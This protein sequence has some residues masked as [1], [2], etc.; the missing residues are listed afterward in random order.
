[1]SVEELKEFEELV[2]DSR[3]YESSYGDVDFCV[4]SAVSLNTGYFVLSNKEFNLIPH[5]A[6]S[7]N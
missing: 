6:F 7:F 2:K 5:S 1:M 3:F 4:P